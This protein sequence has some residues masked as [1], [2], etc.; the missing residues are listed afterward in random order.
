MLRGGGAGTT[1]ERIA[2]PF[3]RVT[4]FLA[5]VTVAPGAGLIAQ[6]A[7][8]VPEARVET[9]VVSP[10]VGYDAGWLHQRLFGHTYR[11]LWTTPVEIPVL[12][13][14]NF[15]GGLIPLRSGGGT[16]TRS[17]RFQGGDG[18]RYI[19]RLVDK[20]PS[21]ALPEDFV[22]T[23][24]DAVVQD[25]VSALHPDAAVVVP[26]L[27]DAVGVL[28]LEPFLAVMPDD[29]ALGESREE[30]AGRLGTLE[31]AIDTTDDEQPG[32]AGS[33]R[34][35][36]TEQLF[37]ELEDNPRN[38]VDAPAFLTARLLDLLL[39]DRDRHADQ[40][41]WAS[42]EV[43]DRSMWRPIPLDRDQAF[44]AYSGLVAW[45]VRFWAPQFV[46]FGEDY[47][48]LV[49]ATWNGR[50]L[51][52]RLL[53]EL[54]RPV[55]D[56][57]GRVVQERLTDSVIDAAVRRMPP[58]H[59]EKSGA[60]LARALKKRRDKIS[61]LV[62]EYYSLLGSYVDIHASD[63]AEIAYVDRVADGQV[64]V[65]IFQRDTERGAQAED[66]YFH[67][68]FSRGVTREIRLF[69]HGADD[70]V[71]VR[72]DVDESIRVHVI[73]GG[74]D[75]RLV[76]SSSVRRS[77]GQT[78]FHDARGTNE[79]L[80]GDQTVVDRHEHLRDRETERFSGQERPG[81]LQVHSRNWG[82]WW[83]PAVLIGAESD[84]GLGIGGGAV[85]YK[86]AFRQ[87]PYKYR[88]R[89]RAAYATG[90]HR[91]YGE[92]L[93]EFPQLSHKVEAEIQL[94]V[95]SLDV[96]NFHGFGNETPEAEHPDSAKVLVKQYTLAPSL[97][98]SAAPNLS[99]SFGPLAKLSDTFA[100]P[101]TVIDASRPRGTDTFGQIG[102]W[103]GAEYD[104]R[105]RSTGASRG[106]FLRARSTLY[107]PVADVDETIREVNG[108]GTRLPQ[109]GRVGVAD[110]GRADRRQEGVGRL[111]LP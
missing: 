35:V 68:R 67:R 80:A 39:G 98:V 47:P 101:G 8:G 94:L 93:A 91:F 54:E 32:L 53:V 40:W 78:R 60:R 36:G 16:Q 105:D 89:W 58:K 84:L 52:R 22:G 6:D 41:R 107:L 106:V 79:F 62:E 20:D 63:E 61:E 18:R 27:L 14:A 12:D 109:S 104:T 28:H 9:R 43:G 38:R 111:S 7:R 37:D 64:D 83:Q 55:W 88:L 23:F 90:V 48:D 82:S 65:R 103:A 5:C 33:Q 2:A 30:F 70:E 110:P 99:F 74:G 81:A 71:R 59:Y 66:P 73:G 108:G 10:G 25:Q 97:T 45:A 3:L 86:Y 15:A 24:V 69:M 85:L 19:F 95:S 21:M 46:S 49:F 13:V 31:R 42:F 100:E 57:V 87:T 50:R 75:D 72:G 4:A 11:D 1:P 26:P 102:V 56:S 17:L 76:D 77:S 92:F 29:P 51:D 96:I 44:I 34:V